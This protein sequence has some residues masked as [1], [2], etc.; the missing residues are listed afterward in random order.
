MPNR[1]LFNWTDKQY[2]AFVEAKKYGTLQIGVYFNEQQA[3]KPD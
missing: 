1:L 3:V 2:Q